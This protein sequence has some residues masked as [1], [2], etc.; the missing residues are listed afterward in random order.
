V[1]EA[2]GRRELQKARTRARI[3]AV[4]QGLFARRGFEPVTITE[5][6]AEAGVSVQTVFNHFASKEDL[7]FSDRAQWVEGA[8]AAVRE[9]G[10]GVRPKAALRRHLVTMVEGYARA[11]ASDPHHRRMI[12]VLDSTPALL[13]HERSLHEEAVALLATELAAAWGCL[14]DDPSGVCR[15]VSAEVTAA[16]WMAAV[17]SIVLDLRSGRTRADDE[18]AIRATVELTDRVL[19]ELDSALTFEDNSAV[20]SACRVG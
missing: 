20:E 17:R 6:A 5:I 16:V 9:R 19:G 2:G 3:L 1:S 13:V 15:T 11:A 18:D 10:A 4:A 7:F 12:E 8:A 14:D